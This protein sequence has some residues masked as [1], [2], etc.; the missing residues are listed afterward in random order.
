[1]S[2]DL[3]WRLSAEN[4]L[5]AL[6]R[7]VQERVLLRVEALARNPRPSASTSLKGTLAGLRRLRV[8]DYRIAYLVDDADFW[9][10]ILAVGHRSKFYENL[11]RSDT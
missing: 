7:D 10:G 3:R 4:D 11:R 9:I 1:M 8:G 6:P 5:H 2:Y